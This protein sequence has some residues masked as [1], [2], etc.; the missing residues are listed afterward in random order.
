MTQMSKRTKKALK[1]MA[2]VKFAATVDAEGWPNVVPLT[3]ARLI[4]Q[5]TMAFVRMM[6]WKTVRNF[7]LNKKL[8]FACQGPGGRTYIA[9][10]EFEKWVTEGPLLEKFENEPIYRYNAYFGANVAGLARIRETLELPGFSRVRATLSPLRGRAVRQ[11]KLAENRGP[12]ARPVMEKWTR[13]LSLKSLAMVDEQ[14]DP[15]ALPHPGIFVRDPESLLF[16]M[17]SSGHP[18][19]SIKPGERLAASV[20]APDPVAYQVKG[21]FAGTADSGRLGVIEVN[22]VFTASPPVPGR[23]IYPPE[24]YG[25]SP[26]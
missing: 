21:M 3:S 23:R 8:S 19:C 22:Q 17:P 1:V 5:D 10:C 16:R 7:E 4:D 24:Q 9:K 14:G 25:E 26:D 2:Y 13:R 15:I 12:M 20:L 11:G 6:A 18:L